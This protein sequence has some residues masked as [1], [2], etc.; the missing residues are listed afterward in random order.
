MVAVAVAD[1]VAADLEVDTLQEVFQ[2]EVVHLE[3][4]HLD[5]HIREED[6]VHIIQEDIIIGGMDQ[7]HQCMGQDQEVRVALPLLLG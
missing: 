3:V 2:A 7:D 1:I 6:Q 5:I 4:A